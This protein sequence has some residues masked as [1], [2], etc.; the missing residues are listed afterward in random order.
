MCTACPPPVDGD[1]LTERLFQSSVHTLEIFS[2]YLGK[3]L[4]LYEILAERGTCTAAELAADAAIDSRYARE[5]LEQQAVAGFLTAQP[6]EGE[7]QSRRF[8]LPVE[9]EAVFVR[10]NDP[11][12]VSPLAQLL[13][14][15]AG[16]LPAVAA[17]YRAGTGVSFAA[18]GDDARNGQGAINRP[19]FS[20]DLT[21]HWIPALPEVHARLLAGNARIADVGCGQGWSTVAVAR[22]Y[23]ACDVIGI[24]ADR[25]SIQ[26]ARALA[27]SEGAGAIFTCADASQVEAE[28]PFDLV[29]ILEALHDMSRPDRVLATFRDRLAPDGAV[30]IADE[31]V[32]D[33]FQAPGDELERMMYGW[34][35]TTCLPTSREQPDSLA[36]GT[37]IRPAT[38]KRL[39]AK[40]GFERCDILDIENDLFRF[41]RLGA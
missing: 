24:D 13:V 10:E 6:A 18:Y 37:A 20:H 31:R 28:G 22:A 8:A 23:P 40:A 7:D 36:I 14:G 4:G 35:V 38:V 32:A 39:A 29:L 19:V 27:E 3:K 21:A 16:A 41:Y 17:A 30:L 12:Y 34:S 11:A 9:H 1:A 25:A 5:W 26:E 2:V 33:A 15:V